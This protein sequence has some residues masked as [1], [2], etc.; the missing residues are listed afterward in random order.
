MKLVCPCCGK[1]I[2]VLSPY[3]AK[4]KEELKQKYRER[5]KNPEFVQYRREVSLK[6]YYKNKEN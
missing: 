6:N 4:H 1:E 5:M 3:Y 2:K